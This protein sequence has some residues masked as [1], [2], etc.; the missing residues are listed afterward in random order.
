MPQYWLCHFIEIKL[1]VHIYKQNLRSDSR[2]HRNI[3]ICSLSL[4]HSLQDDEK[5][6]EKRQHQKL[7][8]QI[9]LELKPEVDT[10]FVSIQTSL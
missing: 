7:H 10:V 6:N 4:P 8:H 1:V 2:L 5:M 9:G 3:C